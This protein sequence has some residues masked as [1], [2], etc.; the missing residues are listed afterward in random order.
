[1]GRVINDL[2]TVILRDTD[3]AFIVPLQV[4]IM[5]KSLAACVKDAEES[6][7]RGA[8]SLTPLLLYI[9]SDPSSHEAQVRVGVI[10]R[11]MIGE[12]E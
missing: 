9:T 4:I 1:M 11:P 5:T 12:E 6:S 10:A 3:Q 2:S 7:L 8:S